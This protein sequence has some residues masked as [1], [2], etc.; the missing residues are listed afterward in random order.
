MIL[1]SQ[2]IGTGKVWRVRRY[3][4][5]SNRFPQKADN[6]DGGMLIRSIGTGAVSWRTCNRAHLLNSGLP[7]FPHSRPDSFFQV[8][9]AVSGLFDGET[10]QWLLF[11]FPYQS[12]PTPTQRTYIWQLDYCPKNPNMNSYCRLQIGKGYYWKCLCSMKT[13]HF[14][15]KT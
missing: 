12:N 13:R 9:P 7:A 1:R 10:V 4:S 2:S 14:F 8:S 3:K 5:E 15:L 11:C 6:A